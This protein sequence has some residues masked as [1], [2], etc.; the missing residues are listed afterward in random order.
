M[1]VLND[2]RDGIIKIRNA[3]SQIEIKGEQNASRVVYACAMC[4]SIVEILNKAIEQ[5]ST[6]QNGEEDDVEEEVDGEP[7]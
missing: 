2:L 6:D 5:V 3:V 4:D 1:N 7:D